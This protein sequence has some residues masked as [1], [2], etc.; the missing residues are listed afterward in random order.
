MGVSRFTRPVQ[1]DEGMALDGFTSGQEFVDGWL[2][3]HARHA[4]VRGSA[5]VYVSHR[6]GADPAAE[7]PAGFYT[8]SSAS[9]ERDLIGG[10][11]LKRNAPTQVPVILLGVLGVDA[12]YHGQGLGKMLLN[13]ASRRAVA[14]A[15]ILGAKALVVDPV[16]EGAKAFYARFG[17]KRI[18]GM[19]R[20]FMPLAKPGRS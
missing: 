17:F 5:V 19:G 7:P 13:D 18:P 14:I 11:W 4:K 10:G 9:V 15:D 16:D 3:R 12:R 20:M 8:L 6:A 2:V 1:L